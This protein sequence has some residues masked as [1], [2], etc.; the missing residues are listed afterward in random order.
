MLRCLF[1]H[2]FTFQSSSSTRMQWH[3]YWDCFCYHSESP[4]Y[5]SESFRVVCVLCSMDCSQ[6]V[7]RWSKTE[8]IQDGAHLLSFGSK[9]QGGVVH[10]VSHQAYP[11]PG[12]ALPLQI[13]DRRLGWCKE[14]VRYV[15]G[16]NA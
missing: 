14:H 2:A 5:G 6:H 1:Q 10:H 16:E 11:V 12:Y 4:D 15:V 3:N 7:P 8:L 9:V 13:L